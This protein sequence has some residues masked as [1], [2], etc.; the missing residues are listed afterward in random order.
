MNG[1]TV[2]AGVGEGKA[3]VLN[4]TPL[5]DCFDH[6][7]KPGIGEELAKYRSASREFASK[8][9]HSM[10]GTVP[11]KVRDIFGAVSAYITNADN[12]QSIEKLISLG[13]TA[14]EAASEVLLNKI[15]AFTVNDDA[16]SS[17]LSQ[18]LI[19]LMLDFV[20]SIDAKNYKR[21]LDIPQPTEPYVLIASDLSPAR[22]LSLHTELIRAVVLEGGQVSSH[23]STVLRDLRIPAIFEVKGVLTIQNGE[24][25][26][27]DA[28]NGTVLVNPPQDM[29]RAVLAQ[30]S[31]HSQDNDFEDSELQVTVAGS[32]GAMGEID[33]LTSYLNHG[34]GLLRTEFLF[35][36]YQQ[37][38]TYKEMV[39]T[40]SSIFSRIPAGTPLTIRTFDFA[41]DKRP[42]FN[43]DLDEIGPL[44]NYGA[45]VGTGLLRNELKAILAAA[46]GR[47]VHIVFPLITMISEAKALN[48]LLQEVTVELKQEGIAHGKSIVA[49]MIETPAAV[50]SA[51]GF[52]ELGEMFL[53]GTSSLAQYASAPREPSDY[54]TPALA[55]M[56]AIACKAA[57]KAGVKVGFAGRFTMKTELL[58][59]FLAM[60]AT[61]FTTDVTEILR[62]RKA[63][64][65]LSELGI[66]PQFDEAFYEKVMETDSGHDLQRLIFEN[67]DLSFAIME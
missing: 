43:L 20:D 50:L 8:L 7:S 27:V 52:A 14:S 33:R 42:L 26:L 45:K 29:V 63:L 19:A 9:Q 16:E 56:I 10:S 67:Y 62:V 6:D 61:Y 21:N 39:F 51:R 37:A 31:F 55:K 4:A 1:I 23:L 53:I 18:E 66:T 13:S 57:H 28:N 64:Q 25:V 48:A 59:F 54:F 44:K 47:E 22:F 24:H 46:V 30:H 12:T 5:F 3:F 32:M 11:D 38:P 41:D 60:G 35:L 65:R 2:S 40:F 36:S 34:L 17:S 58:P 15:K 49:L